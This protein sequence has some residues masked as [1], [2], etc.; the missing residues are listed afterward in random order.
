RSMTYCHG[1]MQR[2]Q[3]PRPWP[4]NTAYDEGTPIKHQAMT[5]VCICGEVLLGERHVEG[6]LFKR[7]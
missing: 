5:E 2:C 3:T 4:D 6:S 1:P 7:A